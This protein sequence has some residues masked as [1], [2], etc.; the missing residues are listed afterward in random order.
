VKSG[1][2]LLSW[3]HGLDIQWS[4]GEEGI[5]GA[6]SGRALAISVMTWG[7]PAQFAVVAPLLSGCRLTFG[8]ILSLALTSKQRECVGSRVPREPLENRRGR[9]PR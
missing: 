4:T 1:R 3:G 6:A 5:P 8:F 7:P 9:R 2:G